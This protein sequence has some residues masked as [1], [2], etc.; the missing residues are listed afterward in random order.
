MAGKVRERLSR[1]GVKTV[2]VDAACGT[3][4]VATT[5]SDGDAT[6]ARQ[7]CDLA[8]ELAYSGSVNAL[9]VTG[10]SGKDLAVGAKGSPC[11]SAN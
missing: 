6:T 4:T 3:V 8:A 11:R 1:P 5:L 9:R 10:D 2:T 7:L